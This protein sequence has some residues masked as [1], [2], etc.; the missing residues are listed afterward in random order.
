MGWNRYHECVF[1][2]PCYLYHDDSIKPSSDSHIHHASVYQ[3]QVSHPFLEIHHPR[4]IMRSSCSQNLRRKS[5]NRNDGVRERQ[6]VNYDSR[7]VVRVSHASLF[8][9]FGCMEIVWC[10]GDRD[11]MPRGWT[12]VFC[13]TALQVLYFHRDLH[14][15][16]NMT[17]VPI[18]F[19]RTTCKT[20]SL[21]ESGNTPSQK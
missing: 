12:S 14:G 4:T 13:S 15:P 7:R 1:C 2:L 8:C 10:D 19:R 21:K 6:H 20:L 9:R 11:R 17:F 5:A 3:S 16:L 18:F